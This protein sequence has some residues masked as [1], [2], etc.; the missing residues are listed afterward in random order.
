MNSKHAT[1]WSQQ[2]CQFCSMATVLL[3]ARGYTFTENKI[4]ITHTKKELLDV[5]PDARSVPQIFMNDKYIG[6]YHELKEFLDANP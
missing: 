6:G 1:I 5:V 3:T 4:G 2:N